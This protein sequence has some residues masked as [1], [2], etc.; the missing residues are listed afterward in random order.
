MT[1]RSIL[2]QSR[3]HVWLYDEDWEWLEKAYGRAG[4]KPIGVSLALKTLIHNVIKE[5]RAKFEE[6]MDQQ[7]EETT[8]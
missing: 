4:A 2:P 7:A 8:T 6:L 3:R 1:K 5:K